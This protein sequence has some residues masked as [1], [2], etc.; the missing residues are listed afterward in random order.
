MNHL[1]KLGMR[2]CTAVLLLLLLSLGTAAAA[3]APEEEGPTGEISLAVLSAYYSKGVESSRHGFVV[4]PS[5][6]VGYGGFSA[7]LWGNVDARPYQTPDDK[8][9]SPLWTETDLNLLYSVSVGDWTFGAGYSY[10]AMREPFNGAERPADQQEF[11]LSV[12]FD[13]LLQPTLTAYKLFENGRRWY[14]QLG[15]LHCFALTDAVSLKLAGT[16]TYLIGG[17]ADYAA[18]GRYDAQANPT[19]ERYDA[20]LDGVLTASLPIGVTERLT[21]TPSLSYAFPLGSDARHYMKANGMEAVA[22]EDRA[23]SFLFG[24]VTVAFGF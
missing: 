9:K 8:T 13:T 21:I 7:N 5:V 17:D 12:G 3:Q 23:A 11:N 24:G 10:F 1:N 6:T 14:I 2:L 16:A 19:G 22:G 18:E 4:Q 20:W 15:I